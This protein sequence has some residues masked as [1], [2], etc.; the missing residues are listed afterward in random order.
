[1]TTHLRRMARAQASVKTKQAD[2]ALAILSPA[3]GAAP[4]DFDLRMFYGRL[5]RDQRK[6]PDAVAQFVAATRIKPA[7]FDAW[8]E[9][10]TV[11]VVAAQYP[12]ALAPFER[13]GAPR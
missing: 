12:Q 4:A 3:V 5:L 13:I 7:A 1:M 10:A 11:M 9:L 8:S 2:K 6:F